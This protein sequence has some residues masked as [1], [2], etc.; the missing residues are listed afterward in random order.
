MVAGEV[1]EHGELKPDGLHPFLGQ[2][3]GGHLHDKVLIAA[4]RSPRHFGVEDLRNRRGIASTAPVRAHG[5]AVGADQAARH[6]HG[7][8]DMPDER[9]R[10]RLSVCPR[11]ADHFQLILRVAVE[12]GKD[13]SRRLP[14]I[15][16]AELKNV[17]RR[18][19]RHQ[20]A[21]GAVGPRGR[22]LQSN[23]LRFPACAQE[24]AVLLRLFRLGRNRAD[25]A[26]RERPGKVRPPVLPA[27]RAGILHRRHLHIL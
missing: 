12:I 11:H 8:Q 21:A 24:Q 9:G 10:C 18:K 25:L 17:L 15:R 5:V 7:T 22:N 3:M 13:E 14:Q 27:P 4:L 1:C 20:R 6:A 23:V 2:R 19:L 16:A 26:C